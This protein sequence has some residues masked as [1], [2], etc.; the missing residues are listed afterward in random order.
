MTICHQLFYE[1][2][3]LLFI[4]CLAVIGS[5]PGMAQSCVTA[6]DMDQPTRTALESTAKR[7]FDMASRGDAAGLKQNAIPGLASSF[8]GIET[9]VRD[10]QENI[11]GAQPT[12]RPP[13]ELK[14]EGDSADQ[15]AEFLCGVFGKSGQTADSAV[16]VI[17][18]LPSGIYAAATVD[19]TTA[20][21]AYSVTFILQQMGTDWKLGGLYY[22][23]KQVNGHDADWFADKARE[24]QKK[25]QSHD[26]WFYYVEARDLSVPVIFMS[27]Q[28]TD[29]L[30]DEMQKIKPVDLPG[31]GN[32]QDLV[33][34][35]K[36]YKLTTI[37]PLVVGKDLDLVVKFQTDSIADTAKTFQDN[38]A[39]IKGI[40]A[41]YPELRDG[42]D[43]VVA[44][45]VAPSGQDYGSLLPM[46]EIK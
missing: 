5:L 44:R 12:V 16:F 2:R 23:E 24:F 22:K 42:F 18:N 7:F 27:T 43:G 37:F 39:V 11:A 6:A 4:L 38:M 33:A 8:G 29:K 15:R 17:P 26:A 20:K 10:N 3:F 45:A 30:Y 46:K 35:G 34:N 41:K 14:Q 9:A 40:L 32:T 36:T 25:G 1:T 19:A 13:F 28:Q 21:G 31:G